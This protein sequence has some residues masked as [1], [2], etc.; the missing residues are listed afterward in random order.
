M[1]KA[2]LTLGAII[3][4]LLVFTI[5]Y[6]FGPDIYYKSFQI[7][8]ESVGNE[9]KY[10][11]EKY[12]YSFIYPNSWQKA[13]YTTDLEA[14]SITSDK[15]SQT[16]VGFFVKHDANINNFDDLMRFVKEDI[17][18][19]E[20]NNSDS[21]TLSVEKTKLNNYDAILW[22]FKRGSNKEYVFNQQYYILDLSNNK[23]SFI[24]C[25][26]ISTDNKMDFGDKDG[27]NNILNSYT[28]LP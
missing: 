9:T 11:D 21:E 1:K 17:E 22:K 27:V 13:D 14:V 7:K 20:E 10:I 12:G 26:T 4:G 3:F 2:I 15:D 28:L 18:Y 25:L 6:I 5:L 19:E 23:K 16:L 8:I 24:R